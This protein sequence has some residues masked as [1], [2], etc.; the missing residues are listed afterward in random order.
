[1]LA[2]ALG[3]IDTYEDK[4]RFEELYHTYRNLMYKVAFDIL[5]NPQDAEDALQKPTSIEVNNS[6]GMYIQ[7]SDGSHYILWDNGE[8]FLEILASKEFGIDEVISI[9]NSV[10]KA[11]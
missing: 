4:K 10:Q 7:Q 3:H 1:M 8:Y 2:A 9:C 5:Q 11:E 6:I